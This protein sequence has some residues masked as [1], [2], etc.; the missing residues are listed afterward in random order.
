MPVAVVALWVAAGVPPPGGGISNTALFIVGA[1]GAAVVTGLV[2]WRLGKRLSSGNI[3]ASA[4]SDLWNES[5]S[6]RQALLEEA[7]GLRAELAS[8]RERLEVADSRLEAADARAAAGRVQAEACRRQIATLQRQV[9]EL[10][11][12]GKA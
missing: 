12:K 1:L 4:A 3:D 9:R 11:R 7:V 5:A 2:T 10:K 6:I 8:L